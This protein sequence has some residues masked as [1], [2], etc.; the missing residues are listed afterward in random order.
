MKEILSH[1][2]IYTSASYKAAGN[3]KVNLR[4][5]LESGYF[6]QRPIPTCRAVHGGTSER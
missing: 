5:N 3:P 6:Q 1:I 4:L 2:G